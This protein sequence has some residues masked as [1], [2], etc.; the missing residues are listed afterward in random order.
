[1]GIRQN[2]MPNTS[3]KLMEAFMDFSGGLNSEV[4]NDK[5]KDTEFPVLENVSLAGRGSA[6]RRYGRVDYFQNYPYQNPTTNAQGIFNY[7]RQGTPSPDL[8]VAHNGKIYLKPYDKTDLQLVPIIDT[9]NSNAVFN[10]QATQLIDA[11]QYKQDMFFAT[12][13]KLCE[14]TY[15]QSTAWVANTA[16]TVGQTVKVGSLVYK[17]TQAGTSGTVTTAFGTGTGIVD[18]SCKWD[19][20]WQEWNAKVVVAYAPTNMEAIYIGTN[21]L[22]A[23]P[24]QY[25]QDNLSA[26][27]LSVAGIQPDKTKG[28]VN[29]PTVFT[30]FTNR[31]S[32]ITSVDYLWEYRLS[33]ATTWTS[34]QA[35][36]Q[37]AAGKTWKFSP[38]TISN[39]DIRLTIRDHSVTT[40]TAQM[41]LSSYEVD[42][43]ENK[44]A[45]TPL[46]SS[47]MNRCRKI[48]LHW[49]RI[50]LA[51]DDKNPFQMYISDLSNPRYFPSTNTIH[52]DTGKQEPITAIVRYRGM[53]IVFTR[54]TIQSVSGKTV[55]T[56]VRNLVHDQVGCAAGLSAK[57][58]GNNIIFL[59]EDGLYMIK[60]NQ[61]VLEAMNVQRI[62]FPIKSELPS[63]ANAS[64]IVHDSQYFLAY[65]D[66][67]LVYRLYYDTNMWVRDTSSKLDIIQ[68][69]YD[70]D[71]V[72]NL[73]KTGKVY[74]H[75]QTVFTDCGEAFTMVVE[76]KFIDLSAAFNNKKLRRLYVLAKHFSDHNVDISVK[77]QADSAVVLDP[78]TGGSVFDA[79]G[80]LVWQTSTSPNMHFYTGTSF[81]TWVMGQSG[82]GDVALSVERAQIRG[83]C[84][85]V[86]VRIEHSEGTNC[87]IFGFGLEFKLKKP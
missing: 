11:V 58:V 84:R 68:F 83:K 63:D 27:S 67:K 42:P 87:E 49:D 16:Y 30:A 46:D 5:L 74:Q 35:Y 34:G 81:G 13:T 33:G 39:Y 43:T 73:T 23:N 44:L 41:I 19:Y 7:F 21:A 57:V 72:Y 26:A 2:P 65:P 75:D 48:L 14:M 32:T 40:T 22:A 59:S 36:A 71:K 60:P 45:N 20:A 9:A 85:R 37:D 28:N 62:D 69:L 31:P 55:E 78:E 17:C 70:G 1:M 51:Q 77:V 76:S 25:V 4:S 86:K 47:A 15:D 56:Y 53:L 61:L 66:R 52:F 24:N 79:N 64:A 82:F 10:F 8:V 12:G 50:L 18:G 6:R 54:S 38:D 3:V 29:Q 80:Y